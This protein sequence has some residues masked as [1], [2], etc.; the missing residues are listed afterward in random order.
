MIHV[1][2]TI[3]AKENKISEVEN[4]IS[5]HY[6]NIHEMEIGLKDYTLSK[7]IKDCATFY[8]TENWSRTLDL[9]EY[10]NSNN[11]LEYS[12]FLQSLCAE[13]IKIESFE[14]M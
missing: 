13:D 5:E 9:V 8:I 6:S 3:I 14:L 11:F 2:F 1:I 4:T 12:K 7:S 10:R